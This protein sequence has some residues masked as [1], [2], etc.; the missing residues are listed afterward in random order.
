MEQPAGK[1]KASCSPRKACGQGLLTACPQ[2]L[3]QGDAVPACM[4]PVG[5]PTRRNRMFHSKHHPSLEV[6]PCLRDSSTSHVEE[7]QGRGWIKQE[8]LSLNS[9]KATLG[10][11]QNAAGQGD[12]A[13]WLGWPHC[14]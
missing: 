2:L 14:D 5:S 3:W 1:Q 13:T 4:M 11:K 12:P 9:L 7:T 8:E 6:L 10:P